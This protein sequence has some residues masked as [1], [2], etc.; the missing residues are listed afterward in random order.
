VK[1]TVGTTVA[2]QVQ[3]DIN[4]Q[5]VRRKELTMEGAEDVMERPTCDRLDEASAW[6]R[7]HATCADFNPVMRQYLRAQWR[8]AEAM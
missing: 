8:S 1:N 4:D 3:E 2:L 5:P 6:E 7:N